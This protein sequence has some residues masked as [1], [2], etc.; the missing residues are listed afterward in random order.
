MSKKQKP[1]SVRH[2]RAVQY[3]RT[4]HRPDAPPPAEVAQWMAE[5][6]NPATYAQMDAYAAM[7]LR[8]RIL[9]LPTMVALM[10]SMI[11]QQVASVSELVRLLVEE[12]LLWVDPTEV[13]Q[14]A[15]SER[16][17]SFP[18]KLFKQVL[19]E[20][21]P[22]MEE[23]ALARSR[24]QPE[25]IE[26]AHNHFGRVLVMDGSTLDV[27]LRKVG[28]LRGA[29]PGVLAGKMA[30]LLNLVTRL[31]VAAW[32]NDD[33][34]AHDLTFR[35]HLLAA[36]IPKDLLIIDR[37]FQDYS[38][39][40]D[41]T[42][43]DVG[44]ITRPKRN[45]VIREVAVLGKSAQVHDR[46][47]QLGGLDAPCRHDLR[48]VEVLHQG[49]WYRYLTNILDPNHLSALDVADL[50][51]RRWRVEDAFMT[52]KRVLGLSY[53]WV[54]SA[55]GVA[56]QVWATWL[57]YA[58]LVDLT[59]AVADRLG[60]LF[61]AISIEMVFRGLYYYTGAVKRGDPRDVVT[62]LADKAHRLGLI[63]RIRSKPLTIAARA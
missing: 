32:F 33:P 21:L 12:G 7:G 9:D 11:W 30:V 31:P 51:R 23:R 42:G 6:V 61:D 62:Y 8:A 60:R 36:L 45:A 24:P 19:L 20:V 57:V 41:L 49:K 3:A 50:Y 58:M 53:L 56:L 43:A 52:V 22:R 46:I 29:P 13:S 54:G 55:N 28:L 27:L 63:K 40:D 10:V 44:F 16:I 2:T 1:S 47:I 48:L 59:D 5:I 39:F 14:Q 38:F 4:K 26:R 25:C 35:D 37:G 17:R 34:K 18:A 15:V